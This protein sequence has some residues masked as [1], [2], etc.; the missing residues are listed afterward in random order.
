[1]GS[2]NVYR[3]H[4]VDATLISNLFIDHYMK[5]AN[6]AQIKVYLYLVRLMSA[7]MRTSISDIADRFNHTEK[8]VIRSLKYWEKN[9]LLLLDYDSD[10]N[11]TG[12]HLRDLPLTSGI[13]SGDTDKAGQHNTDYNDN[14]TNNNSNHTDNNSNHDTTANKGTAPGEPD[15]KGKTPEKPTYTLD[16]LKAFK[17]QEEAQQILFVAEQYI[18]K[19]L[20]PTEI[21]SIFYIYDGLGF[22]TDLIDY[23]IQYCVGRGKRDFRYIEKVAVTWAEAKVKTPKQAAAISGKYDKAVYTIMTALGKNASPVAKEVDY[24]TKWTKTY[25]Y[26][27]DV[28]L[29][30][31]NRTVLAVDSH[32]FEYADGVLS[33]WFKANIHH[34]N[35]VKLADEKFKK[36]KAPAGVSKNAFNQFQQNNYDF[37]DL[38]KKLLSN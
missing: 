8:D 30:A 11:L 3:D 5:D 29:E 28:I 38:E 2:L 14:H 7:N 23:L 6:D 16:Q 37:E 13:S 25:G 15:R 26:T 21:R 1:M 19:T 27:I 17:A 22:S 18:G 20:S 4:Y 32:R 31:C 35:D 24:I 33:N 34:L 36:S 12:I 10:K 9:G